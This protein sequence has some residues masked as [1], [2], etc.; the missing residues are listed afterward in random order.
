[1]LTRR[2]LLFGVLSSI[3]VSAGSF[4]LYRRKSIPAAEIGTVTTFDPAACIQHEGYSFTYYT[5]DL[6]GQLTRIT[7][8][9]NS[10]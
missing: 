10:R 3:A 6:A 4:L 5:Y 9:D 2:G 1:M 7:R 8:I